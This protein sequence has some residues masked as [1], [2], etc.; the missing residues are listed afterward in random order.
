MGDSEKLVASGCLPTIIVQHPAQ[1][2]ATPD[3]STIPGVGF[4]RSDQAVAQA[5]LFLLLTR[6]KA[7][8]HSG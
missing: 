4:L 2:P 3:G 6:Q 5:L 7:A 1:P 8:A